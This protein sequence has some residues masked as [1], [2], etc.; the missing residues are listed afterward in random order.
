[1]LRGSVLL[2]LLAACFSGAPDDS[3]DDSIEDAGIPSEQCA[4]DAG[5]SDGGAC[6]LAEADQCAALVQA[7][8]GETCAESPGCAASG[9]LSQY[10]PGRC[11]A[12]LLDTQTFPLCQ[13]GSCDGLVARACGGDPALKECLDAPGCAPALSLQTRASDA[14]ASQQEIDEA[15]ASCVQAL[16]D[17]IVFAPCP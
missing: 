17:Q 5:P 15:K 16:E 4:A 13:L 3:I 1:M 9:L 10:E 2:L 14:D 7:T 11:P 12:A 6:S 8:C